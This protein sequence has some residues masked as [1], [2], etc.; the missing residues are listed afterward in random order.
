M[1]ISAISLLLLAA[2][3]GCATQPSSSTVAAKTVE[4]TPPQGVGGRPIPPPGSK[5]TAAGQR[6]M[7]MLTSFMTGTFETIPQDV[8]SGDSQPVTLHVK[9]VWP[10]AKGEIW[11]Y[12][13]YAPRK[14]LKHPF[15]QRLLRF[16]EAG[17]DIYADPFAL[18]D[19]E[20]WAG[21]WSKAKPFAALDRSSLHEQRGCRMLFIPNMESLFTGGTPANA[22]PADTPRA[23]YQRSEYYVG[24]ASI[25]SWDHEFDRAGNQVTGPAGPWEFRKTAL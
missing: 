5:P 14:D 15:R 10:D 3:C 24:S 9:Q 1:K 2:L 17:G 11:L 20:R 21:E 12:L 22:C 23:A 16:R 6:S 8:G 18:P 13:E 19:A 7:E 4:D 25:R